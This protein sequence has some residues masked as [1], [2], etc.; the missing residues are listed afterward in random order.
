MERDQKL[1][2]SRA[3]RLTDEALGLLQRAMLERWHLSGETRRLSRASRAAMLDLSVGTAE[4]I[5]RQEGNDRAVLVQAFQCLDLAWE[6]RYCEPCPQG[7]EE[8]SAP[9]DEPPAPV[10]RRSARWPRPAMHFLAVCLVACACIAVLRSGTLVK[11]PPTPSLDAAK[12]QALAESSLSSGRTAYQRADFDQA[13]IHAI[14]AIRVAR[15]WKMVHLMAD[16]LRL[17]GDALVAQGSL[18]EG[19]AI[20]RETLPLWATFHF[21]HGHASLLEALGVAEARRGRLNEARTFLEESLRRLK[22]LND[23]GGIAGVSRSLGSVA[24]VSGDLQVAHQWYASALQ[25]IKA[26]P[27]KGM[28]ADLRALDALL[29]RDEGKFARAASELGECLKFWES[30]GH[31]R[32]QATTRF[33][34]ATVFLASG[35]LAKADAETNQAKQLF[36]EVGDRAGMA[37]CSA[38]LARKRLVLGDQARRIEEF[39]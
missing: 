8:P 16:A 37:Q 31:R 38:L 36:A 26:R 39:F 13:E 21:P 23:P 30:I 17:Q 1:R 35:D 24:A 22:P 9:P 15:E 2:R 32:W 4:R 19:V 28:Q 20:Y 18:E 27:D 6:D 29:L 3:V 33:Q 5:L 12:A 10:A 14:R 34:R 11:S 25:A 7:Q